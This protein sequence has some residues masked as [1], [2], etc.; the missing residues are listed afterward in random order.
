MDELTDKWGKRYGAIVRL[1]EN[2]WEEFIPFLDYDVEIRTV[3]CSTNDRVA[4]R[5]IPPS[6]QGQ[7][8]FPDRASSPEMSVSCD[9]KPRPDRSRTNPMDDALEAR[10]QRVRHHFQRPLASR[11]NLL[12]ENAGALMKQSRGERQ[13][14]GEA[15]DPAVARYFVTVRMSKIE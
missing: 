11:R 2:A 7:R 12:N 15:T 5:P 14:M 10:S 6:S 9:Q 3:I 1:W 8:S 13:I 4:E